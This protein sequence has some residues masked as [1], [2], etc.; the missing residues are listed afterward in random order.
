MQVVSL[1]PQV[2]SE[3]R[4]RILWQEL[5]HAYWRPEGW[6]NQQQKLTNKCYPTWLLRLCSRQLLEIYHC[7]LC[8]CQTGPVLSEPEQPQACDRLFQ[9]GLR[10]SQ[11]RMLILTSVNARG[12]HSCRRESLDD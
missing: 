8:I 11:R 5:Q 3:A 1:Q 6:S 4:A 9:L 7:L 12:L 10:L 2:L